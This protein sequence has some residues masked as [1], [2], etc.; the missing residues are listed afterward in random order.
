MNNSRIHLDSGNIAQLMQLAHVGIQCARLEMHANAKKEPTEYML[1]PPKPTVNRCAASNG[2]FCK[3]TLPVRSAH[4]C[5]YF[6]DT[7]PMT[8][9]RCRTLKPYGLIPPFHRHKHLTAH[10][11]ESR[12]RANRES[13]RKP[14]KPNKTHL[15]CIIDLFRCIL[16]CAIHARLK[17]HPSPY[18]NYSLLY[19][20]KVT[21]DFTTCRTLALGYKGGRLL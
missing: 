19:I 16:S 20:L 9:Q 15:L 8:I 5:H 14:N 21:S 3:R 13:D 4:F 11:L 2:L 7:M 17:Y 1:L 18:M 6:D 12:I 10:V